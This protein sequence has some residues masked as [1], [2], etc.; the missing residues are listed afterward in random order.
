MFGP[1]TFLENTTLMDSV[2]S[3]QRIVSVYN[4]TEDDGETLY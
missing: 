3:I 1:V 2:N 4:I